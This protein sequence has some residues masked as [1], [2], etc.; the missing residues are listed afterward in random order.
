MHA[1]I[2]ISKQL[3]PAD[4]ADE[5]RM[6][7]ISEDHETSDQLCPADHADERR[8]KKSAKIRRSASNCVPQISQMNAERKNQ[9]RS[10]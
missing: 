3:C 5:R 4:Y 6:K 10:V 2:E 8:E 9:R 7:N 1:E